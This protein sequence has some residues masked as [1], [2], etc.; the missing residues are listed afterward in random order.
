M[1]YLDKEPGTAWWDQ[2]RGCHMQVQPDG[3]LAPWEPKPSR[4]TVENLL[5]EIAEA[6][7]WR[8]DGPE[9][10][11]RPTICDRED[12]LFPKLMDRD[13]E[14][15]ALLRAEV[16]D[17]QREDGWTL[18]RRTLFL[19]RLADTC[20][21]LEAA[22]SVG[23]SR[24]SARKLYRR[25]PAFRAAWD[26]ALA[27]SVAV[28]AETAFH[29]AR[30]GTETEVY[31]NGHVVGHRTV[32]HDRLLMYLLRVRDPFNYAPIDEVDRWQRQ[33]GLAATAR[34]LDLASASPPALAQ[35]AADHPPHQGNL[36]TSC[37]PAAQFA[38]NAPPN[39]GNLETSPAIRWT[40]GAFGFARRAVARPAAG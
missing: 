15:R 12:Q 26:A 10:N 39:Q 1:R 40:G 3:S 13:D 29:R 31:W 7:N 30:F 4:H 34:P 18:A 35:P 5:A 9:E 32:H 8:P 2:K 37:L 19:E 23:L 20:S 36:E 11:K 27:Q 16:P 38:A 21:V 14:E 33:R 25:A 6:E 22:A 28:L 17:D 24:Q